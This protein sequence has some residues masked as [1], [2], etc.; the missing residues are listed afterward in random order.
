MLLVPIACV[1]DV[2]YAAMA[3]VQGCCPLAPVLLYAVRV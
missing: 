3:G 2:E 1:C